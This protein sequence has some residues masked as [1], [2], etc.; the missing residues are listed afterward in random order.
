MVGRGDCVGEE[1]EV[2]GFHGSDV[3]YLLSSN[4]VDVETSCGGELRLR[5]GLFLFMEYLSRS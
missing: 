5:E 3:M 4:R 1:M 2:D